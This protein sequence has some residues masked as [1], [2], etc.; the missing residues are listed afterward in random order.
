M[1][2]LTVNR[3]VEPRS[4]ERSG[5]ILLKLEKKV[6]FRGHVYLQA[7]R[8]QLIHAALNWLQMNNP[9]H[10]NIL[11]DITNIDRQQVNRSEPK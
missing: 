1:Y 9:L 6:Q 8:P 7:V 5:T 10:V 3:L 11:I 4:P 2:L